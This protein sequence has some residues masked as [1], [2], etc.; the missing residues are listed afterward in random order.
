[1]A[2][3]I[4]GQVANFFRFHKSIPIVSAPL[5]RASRTASA[6]AACAKHKRMASKHLGVT[7]I[8]QDLAEANHR[9]PIRRSRTTGFGRGF[10]VTGLSG[11]QAD[12]IL[13]PR[14]TETRHGDQLASI[15]RSVI[16]FA[17]ACQSEI[18]EASSLPRQRFA[19]HACRAAALRYFTFF[20]INT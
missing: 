7:F 14:L 19:G 4:V 13:P 5:I 12:Q 15:C 20:G 9:D 10:L 16:C 11:R 1:M 8:G 3:F 18:P 2:K 17:P 6:K